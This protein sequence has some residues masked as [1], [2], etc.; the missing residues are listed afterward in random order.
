M[1][2]LEELDLNGIEYARA[3]F[4]GTVGSVDVVHI[5]QWAVSANLKQSATG[6]EKYPSRAF[7]VMVNH[8]RKILSVS[9]GFYG[10]VVDKTIVKFDD[11]MVDIKNGLYKDYRYS[12]YNADGTLTEMKGAYVICDNGYL[13]WSTMMEP[14]KYPMSI[15]EKNGQRPVKV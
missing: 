8:R 12:L 2:S 4:P 5:R 10:S 1:P 13:N 7:E 15:P 6:K 14:S 11:A 3:G 9:T